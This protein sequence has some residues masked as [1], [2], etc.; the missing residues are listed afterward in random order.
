[1]KKQT[2]FRIIELPTHQVLLMK[3]WDEEDE[4]DSI[5]MI[6][7]HE[8]MEMKVT[9]GYDSE[10]IRDENFDNFKK[11]TCQQLINEYITF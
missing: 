11:E 1:M 3:T 2:I 8:G 4:S 10:E 6:I 7:N 5:Q 9:F